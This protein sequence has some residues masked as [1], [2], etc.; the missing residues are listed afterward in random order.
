MATTERDRRLDKIREY[1]D[2]LTELARRYD[3]LKWMAEEEKTT[4]AFVVLAEAA[5]VMTVASLDQLGTLL[6]IMWNTQ[7]RK[8]GA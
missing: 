6:E 5:G 7:Q 8:D 1:A 3:R 2:K 4:D